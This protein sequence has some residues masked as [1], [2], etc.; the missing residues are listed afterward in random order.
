M[1]HGT[2]KKI[3]LKA[4]KPVVKANSDVFYNIHYF[5]PS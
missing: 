5:L 2:V 3:G 4:S 1:F